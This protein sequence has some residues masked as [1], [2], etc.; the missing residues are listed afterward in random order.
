LLFYLWLNTRKRVKKQIKII[1]L[2]DGRQ[3]FE[4]LKIN[5]YPEVFFIQAGRVNDVPLLELEA[6]I[7]GKVGKNRPSDPR[8][9]DL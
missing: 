5:A 9:L 6:N 8:V 7:F 1:N 2:P 3:C 4:G